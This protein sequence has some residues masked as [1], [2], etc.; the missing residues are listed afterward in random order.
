M[1]KFSNMDDGEN[2][3]AQDSGTMGE[4]KFYDFIESAAHDLQAPLR[5]LSVLIERVFTKNENQF[6][7]DAREY[8]DRI[9]ACIGQMR[10][11]IDGLMD[12]TRADAITGAK[13]RC[14]LKTIATEVVQRMR[15]ENDNNEVVV[16]LHDLPT[17]LGNEIQYKQLFKNLFENSMKFRKLDTIPRIQ[18]T[19]ETSTDEEKNCSAL[20]VKKNIT[21]LKFVTTG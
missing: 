6:D 8:I 15:E 17:L 1:G 2:K 16:E 21:E 12:L 4:G 14:D 3:N 18:V 9:E 10:S 20:S 19:T 7:E 11:L 13:E 5:K